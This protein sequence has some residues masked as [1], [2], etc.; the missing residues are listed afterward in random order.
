MQMQIQQ[1]DKGGKF[2]ASGGGGGSSSAS[3]RALPNSKATSGP[4]P[5][6]FRA[7]EINAEKISVMVISRYKKRMRAIAEI[8]DEEESMTQQCAVLATVVENWTAEEI[9]DLPIY[10]YIELVNLI[11][12]VFKGQLPKETIGR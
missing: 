1:R 5:E 12:D 11:G 6:Q 8:E 9:A 7:F 4:E 3:I 2:M 10:R